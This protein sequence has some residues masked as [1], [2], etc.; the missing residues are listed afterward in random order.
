[1][2][3][4]DPKVKQS[5][6]IV[7]DSSTVTISGAGTSQIQVYRPMELHVTGSKALSPTGSLNVDIVVKLS[8]FHGQ[9]PLA[10]EQEI[11]AASIVERL[12]PP[13]IDELANGLRND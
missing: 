1:M 13:M 8:F 9:I 5:S 11:T 4:T 3:K 6:N 10:S 12:L 2:K 7:H